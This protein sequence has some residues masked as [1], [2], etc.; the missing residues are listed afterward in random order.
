MGYFIN[1]FGL[2]NYRDDYKKFFGRKHKNYPKSKVICIYSLTIFSLRDLL[3][4]LI[5]TF[6]IKLIIKIY[7][8]ISRVKELLQCMI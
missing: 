4:I 1:E 6:I 8:K 3:R 5:R 7:T 2:E